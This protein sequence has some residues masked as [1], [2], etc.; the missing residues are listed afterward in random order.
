MLKKRINLTEKFPRPYKFALVGAGNIGAT[1]A[2]IILRKNLGDIA[3]IDVNG[4]VAEGKAL[5]LQQAAAV[6]PCEASVSGGSDYNLIKGADVVIV[7]AGLARKPGMSRDD[8]L[9]KNAEIIKQVAEN[10]QKHAPN[11]FVIVITNPLDAMVALMQQATGF[12]THMVVGM[13]GV[14]D[15]ARYK[16]FLSMALNISVADIQAF[17][18]GGHGD[19]MVPMPVYTSIAGVP[20][21]HFIDKGEISAAKV[22]EILERT[23]NGGAEIVGLLKT[24]SAFYAPAE[25]AITMAVSYL[26]D[27]KRTLP[28]AA[29]VNNAYG[30]NGMYLGVPV[31]IGSNG[32][33]KIVELELNSTEQKGLD[34]SVSAVQELMKTLTTMGYYL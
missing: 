28:C 27:Q 6:I 9:A 21:Q 18:L 26:F 16:T 33:E 19:T 12:P 25:S 34:H 7:T 15:T 29:Y 1:M 10:I 8:L 32:V 4:D 3:L 24:G 20:L 2:H 31:V 5:D 17:V 22:E 11:A 13:A 23:K 14:L 30:L